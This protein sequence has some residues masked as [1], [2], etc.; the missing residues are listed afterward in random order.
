MPLPRSDPFRSAPDWAGACA[1]H[2]RWHHERWR[3][4]LN[5]VGVR[6]KARRLPS[7]HVSL[8]HTRARARVINRMTWAGSYTADVK[9]A[10]SL[11]L[12]FQVS[13]PCAVFATGPVTIDAK[14]G[15][16]CIMAPQVDFTQ[17]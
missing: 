12:V 13:L 5:T 4:E 11:M 2:V 10:G 14:G 3:T 6:P 16:N 9:T 7:R 1:E 17:Q 8:A 15:T